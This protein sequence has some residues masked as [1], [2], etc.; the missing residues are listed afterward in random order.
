M[1]TLVASFFDPSSATFSH[2]V[3]SAHGSECAII[4]PVL[5]YDAA[6]GRTS[7][8]GADEII[9]FVRAHALNVE[10]LLE[11]HAHADHL[12]AAAY[13]RRELGG[14]VAISAQICEVQRFFRQVYDLGRGFVCDGSQFDHLFAADES[15]S[16]GPLT[17]QALHVPGHTP[18]DIAYR[19]GDDA[20][21]VGDTLFMP[22]VGTARCDFPGGDAGML[23]RSI[24]RL[25]ALPAETRLYLCHDYP[26]TDRDVCSQTT[27][28]RQRAQNIHVRDGI[29]ESAFVA[30][31]AQRDATLDL[32]RLMLPSIQVNIRAGRLPRPGR[33]GVRYLKIPLD[34]M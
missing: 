30:L 26:A 24:R 23:Y 9:D 3:Y 17:A 34:V 10:W 27:V 7:T 29:T 28:A 6:S 1:K 13:L 8:A 11:T 4:D 16:I 22:D 33:N 32:P 31:R 2:V 25:L 12:S 15:F 20:V 18:A 5:R 21:F 14:R 19:V